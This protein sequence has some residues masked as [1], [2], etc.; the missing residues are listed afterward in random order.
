MTTFNDEAV[1]VAA[2]HFL[3]ARE[4][5]MS[6][7]LILG[8]IGLPTASNVTDRATI[9]ALKRTWLALQAGWTVQHR[10]KPRYLQMAAE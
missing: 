1:A 4:Q 5:G 6:N 7:R 8:S 2:E 3:W 9:D 10:R